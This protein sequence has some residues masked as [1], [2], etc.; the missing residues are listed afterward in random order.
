MAGA[1]VLADQLSRTPSIE[2][3]LAG[4]EKLWRAVAEDKQKVGRSAARWFL[5]ASAWQLRVRRMMLRAARLPF[6]DRVVP[7]ALA[8]KSSAL[9]TD[10]NR[11]G[12]RQLADTQRSGEQTR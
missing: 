12:T 11:T 5:P 9:I 4:Y 8:G 3:A 2:Q 1:Y 7:A 6:V 10:L